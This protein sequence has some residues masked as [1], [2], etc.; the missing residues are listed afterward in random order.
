MARPGED[1]PYPH[2]PSLCIPQHSTAGPGG[3]HRAELLTGDPPPCPA[4]LPAPMPSSELAGGSGEGDGSL[5]PE[6]SLTRPALRSAPPA[7]DGRGGCCCRKSAATFV[8]CISP[9]GA[10]SVLRGAFRGHPCMWLRGRAP[11]RVQDKGYCPRGA[12]GT[13]NP[14]LQ[15]QSARASAV[16]AEVGVGP[17]PERGFL[18]HARD[19]AQRRVAVGSRDVA[20]TAVD[21]LCHPVCCKHCCTGLEPGDT[22]LTPDP[23][24]PRQ[25]AMRIRPSVTTLTQSDPPAAPVQGAFLLPAQ[26][27]QCPVS[28]A[29]GVATPGDQG[30][31]RSR[32]RNGAQVALPAPHRLQPRL[33][34]AWQVSTLVCL[35]LHKKP[36]Q[37]GNK[38]QNSPGGSKSTISPCKLHSFVSQRAGSKPGAPQVL[39]CS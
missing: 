19:H 20:V 4:R 6:T 34:H 26:H 7:A 9:A 12:Q 1:A 15:K 8:A 16:G 36:F 14:L 32:D 25:T 22:R 33:H 30:P 29:W 31:A 38:D 5:P 28:R 35:G 11:S 10:S 2:K 18:N 23:L 17:L 24:L 3:P 13:G 39:N 21:T 27:L 37:S